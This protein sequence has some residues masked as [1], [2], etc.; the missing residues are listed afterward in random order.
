M[1]ADMPARDDVEAFNSEFAAALSLPSP[2][3]LASM[4]TD[5]AVMISNGRVTTGREALLELFRRGLTEPSN[6]TFDSKHVFE[7]GDV[8]VDVGTILRDG[9]PTARYVVI[10]RRQD[11]GSLKLFVDVPLALR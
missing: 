3:Q 2:E 9:A 10:H 11:D 7:D 1:L 5:D 8:V 6:T 4:Y